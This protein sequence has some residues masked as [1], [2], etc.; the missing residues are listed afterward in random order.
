MQKNRTALVVIQ[1]I[2]SFAFIA[3][4]F[5]TSAHF[6]R[7]ANGWNALGNQITEKRNEGTSGIEVILYSIALLPT[8]LVGRKEKTIQGALKGMGII[9][10]IVA[11]P[12][13][14]L[15]LF[16]FAFGLNPTTPIFL[17]VSSIIWMLASISEETHI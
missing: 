5:E 10:L 12:W 3:V 6:D 4:H 11:I 7:L 13:L 15:A 9:G 2:L 8:I 17:L 1:L 16:L 14:A